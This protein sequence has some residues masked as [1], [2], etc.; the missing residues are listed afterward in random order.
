MM[1]SP[2]L[3]LGQTAELLHV[4]KSTLYRLIKDRTVRF[5]AWRIG[6]DWRVNREDLERWVERRQLPTTSV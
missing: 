6:S 1:D 3:T 4:H 2:I 5:P